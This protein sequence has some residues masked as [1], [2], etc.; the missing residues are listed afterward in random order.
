MSKAY[1]R[2]RTK[3]IS[4]AQSAHS[5]LISRYRCKDC[6][7]YQQGGKCLERIFGD[8]PNG[9]NHV[10]AYFKLQ[11]LEQN[12]PSDISVRASDQFEYDY[13]KKI[14]EKFIKL[15]QEVEG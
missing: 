9:D 12:S 6:L 3:A 13:D 7:E 1:W 15:D 8:E 5:H 11:P 4:D 2:A 10:C 14:D